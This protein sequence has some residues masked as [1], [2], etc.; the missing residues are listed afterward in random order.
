EKREAVAVRGPEVD[1]LAAGLRQ[2]RAELAVRQR[3]RERQDAGRDPRAQDERRRARVLRHDPG[4]QEH[5]GADHR[6]DDERD[7]VGEGQAANELALV[8]HVA[9]Y[10]SSVHTSRRTGSRSSA[11]RAAFAVRRTSSGTTRAV[12]ASRPAPSAS[13]AAGSFTRKIRRCVH[14][15]V[16]PAA[17]ITVRTSSKTPARRASSSIG[18]ATVRMY[19]LYASS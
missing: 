11:A 10:R 17:G 15:V 9:R 2:Q 1:I 3:A 6:A 12:A 13:A 14:S 4:L 16:T 8:G 5:A 18:T 19:S 7:S